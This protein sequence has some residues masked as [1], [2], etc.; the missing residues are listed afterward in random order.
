[1]TPNTLLYDLSLSAGTHLIVCESPA[2]CQALVKQARAMDPEGE[3]FLEYPD[4]QTLPYDIT[5]PSSHI[6][7][8]RLKTLHAL[9]S[10]DNLIIIAPYYAL[11][12]KAPPSSFVSSHHFQLKNASTHSIEQL[13]KQL[14]LSNYTECALVTEPG[15]YAVR[16]SLIDVFI[17]G[18]KSPVRIDFFD[19][20]IDSLKLF[21][22]KTQL[23]FTSIDAIDYLPGSEYNLDSQSIEHFRSHWRKLM[24]ESN[25]PLYRKVSNADFSDML[26]QYMPFF[27]EK[28][29]S[30][31]EYLNPT[32]SIHII[33]KTWS[34]SAQDLDQLIEE[35]YNEAKYRIDLPP[36]PPS[37]IY[38]SLS[39]V[40]EKLQ[41]FTLTCYD[42]LQKTT[43]AQTHHEEIIPSLGEKKTI[44]AIESNAR[45][46][47]V[48]QLLIQNNLSYEQCET[49]IAAT[50]SKSKLIVSP[51]ALIF[52]F[53]HQSLRLLVDADWF[54]QAKTTQV[55]TENE[56][57][58][59]TSLIDMHE[60]QLVVHAKQGIGIYHG[61]KTITV[62]QI[63][64]EFIV[65]SYRDDDRLYLPVNQLSLVE[66]YLGLNPELVEL[67]T[68]GSGKWLKKKQ[69]AEKKIEDMAAKLLAIYATRAQQQGISHT[70]DHTSL[71]AFAAACDFDLT[72]DQAKATDTILEDLSLTK[73]ME[74]LLCADVGF[75]KT[76]VAMRASYAVVLGKHQVIV[77]VPTTLLAE[78]HA[79]SFAERFQAFATQVALLTRH[80]SLKERR[81]I[82]EQ[83]NHGHIDILITTHIILNQTI[84]T[85]HLGLLV[86]D[87]EHRFGVKQKEKL[88]AIKSDV[89]ILSLTATPIPRTLH[90]SL[91]GIKDISIIQT[92][93]KARIPT[94]SF[95]HRYQKALIQESLSRELLRGGQAFYLHNRVSTIEQ[96][97]KEIQSLIP[98]ARIAVIHGQLHEQIAEKIMLEFIQHQHDILVCT[99]IIESGIDIPNANTILIERA[100]KLGLA[101]LH[102]IRGRVGRSSR[103][104]YAY[105]LTPPEGDLPK[106]AQRRLNAI[107]KSS[108][109]GAGYQ[110]ASEDLDIRGTGEILGDEQSGHAAMIGLHLYHELLDQAMHH[111]QDGD[112]LV[113]TQEPVTLEL[114]IPC[115]IPSDYMPSPILRLEFY[116]KTQA[117][118]DQKALIHIRETMRDRFGPLPAP[119]LM[120]IQSRVYQL[121]FQALGIHKINV[122][123]KK[124][125]T[126]IG[127]K[128]QINPA[129]LIAMIQSEPQTYQLVKQTQLH[130]SIG[131]GNLE[132]QINNGFEKLLSVLTPEN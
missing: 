88:K 20:T 67:D 128:T 84:E 15:Q 8:K 4:W 26:I 98:S 113:N 1:M 48:E 18:Q 49:W 32:C 103:Q 52:G 27:H 73:P 37:A 99:T 105:F 69:K 59:E 21:S 106:D 61:L 47:Q 110:I 56:P 53:N 13:K 33:G 74:R 87:E 54:Q 68:L 75:G 38:D 94:R 5:P 121:Q 7:A 22:P 9:C 119:C 80:T 45:R 2:S 63:Q 51:L 40:S 41:A 77:L 10:Q 120:L 109:L 42:D 123:K 125:I 114:P 127:P 111:D 17:N 108:S 12:T 93:P 55:T 25:H 66:P 46:Q 126:H 24:D 6:I 3:R 44:I 35:R 28:T 81:K 58:P 34:K 100:D 62:N 112:I 29:A 118:K 91:S 95:V 23:S 96:C 122:T 16:G 14:R 82:M 70:I 124:I 115:T 131:D 39:V 19:D 130:Y 85:K 36:I 92:P 90:L 71:A 31:L 65:I 78:Q 101:Q 76:E 43:S 117:C 102:Q 89:D 83:W 57:D 11:A 86:I 30:L 104:A 72:P 129:K 116:R 79:R 107:E 60:G 132:I 50:Q 97:A 64:Q